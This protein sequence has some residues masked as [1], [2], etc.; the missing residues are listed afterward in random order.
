MISA[1]VVTV[2]LLSSRLTL[3]LSRYSNNLNITVSSAHRELLVVSSV[4]RTENINTQF[5]NYWALI[6]I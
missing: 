1:W 3:F 6:D 5:V 4:Q 2:S